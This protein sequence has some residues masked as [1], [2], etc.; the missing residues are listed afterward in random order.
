M[1]QKILRIID[2]N[3]NRTREG[4]RVVEDFCRF[5][6]GHERLCEQIKSLRHDFSRATA[7]I[8]E[9]AIGFRDTPGDVGTQITTPAESTRNTPADVAVASCKRVG[10]A[11][12]VV[13]EYAKIIDPT[14]GFVV[15]QIRY[16]FYAI[17]QGLASRTTAMRLTDVRLYVLITESA[18]RGGD[19]LSAARDAVAGGASVLQLREK[20][21][22]GGELLVRA[23]R[24]VELCRSTGTICIV[25]D[26]ADIAHLAGADGVHVG[27]GDLP[28][29]EARKLVGT[30]KLVGVSTHTI[31]QARQA[32]VDGADYIGVGPVFPS[33]T[34]PRDILPGLDFARQAA[35]EISIPVVAIAGI[36]RT[37]IDAVV[38]CGIR[39]VAMTS[40]IVGAG[41]VAAAA[42]EI[43][44]RL[45]AATSA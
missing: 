18:C 30:G 29:R 7:A 9:S 20:N 4:L 16:R 34:K 33:S 15:E 37:N 32:V 25:N 38:D 44:G 11:L 22:D 5:V 19:W 27:Q 14:S 35:R 31:E 43:R 40:A 13:E 21:L 10:E 23:R 36:D 41:D 39:S 12:R 2:A 8:A 28:A 42:R 26:R 3:C 24:L 45:P 1:N 6:L 17:E